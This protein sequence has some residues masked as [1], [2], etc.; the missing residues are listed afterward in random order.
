MF[1]CVF[2]PASL[3]RRLPGPS[4]RIDAVVVAVA[5]NNETPERKSVWINEAAVI[6]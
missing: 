3:S 1:Y 2:A 6:T 5:K 4:V